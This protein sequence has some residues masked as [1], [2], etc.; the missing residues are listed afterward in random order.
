[1]DPRLQYFIAVAPTALILAVMA[2]GIALAMIYRRQ[3]PWTARLVVP[4]L[5]ALAA[6]VI[7]TITDADLPGTA[8]F[9]RRGSRAC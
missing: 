9:H 2:T 8:L 5:V 3:R 1:M 4:G 7:G 6:N